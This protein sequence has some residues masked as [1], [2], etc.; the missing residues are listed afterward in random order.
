MSPPAD[1]NQISVN[2]EQLRSFAEALRFFIQ[3]T[4]ETFDET[5]MRLVRLSETWDDDGFEQFKRHFFS[6]RDQ[7]LTFMDESQRLTQAL[8]RDAERAERLM[9]RRTGGY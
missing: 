8:D 5:N 6:T 4:N 3:F 7:L 2:P 1:D 9:Q